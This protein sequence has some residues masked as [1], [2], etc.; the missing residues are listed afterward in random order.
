[1]GREIGNYADKVQLDSKKKNEF[2]EK[3]L[4]N[5]AEQGKNVSSKGF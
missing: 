4:L 1:M 5:A 2:N 3:D